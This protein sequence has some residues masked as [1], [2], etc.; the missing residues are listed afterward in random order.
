MAKKMNK[1]LFKKIILLILLFGFGFVIIIPAKPIYNRFLNTLKE[2]KPSAEEI[3]K[4]NYYS[5]FTGKISESIKILQPKI[6]NEV[7][8]LIAKSILDNCYKSETSPILITSLIWVESGFN[9]MSVSKL[10]AIG[11]MQVMYPIWKEE[12]ELEHISERLELFQINNNIL[13]GTS[14][15]KKHLEQNGG[16][17]EKALYL[18]L[19]LNHK[20]Y[21]EKVMITAGRIAI[22]IFN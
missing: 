6:D 13:A 16:D 14:I 9:Q 18:Y 20:A 3:K 5:L 1:D 15:L 8:S 21:Y 10:E 22:E 19:G 2:D 11:L 17:I 12:G 7:C 4:E